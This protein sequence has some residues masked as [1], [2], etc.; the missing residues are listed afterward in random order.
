MTMDIPHASGTIREALQSAFENLA[1]SSNLGVEGGEDSY[2]LG[3]DPEDTTKESSQ[4]FPWPVPSGKRIRKL[5]E[6]LRIQH[7]CRICENEEDPSN[8]VICRGCGPARRSKWPAHRS[9]L[10]K[11]EDHQPNLPLN[12]A[13]GPEAPSCE[14]IDYKTVVYTTSLLDSSR[15]KRQEATEDHLEDLWSTWFGVPRNQK[16]PHYPQLHIYPRLETMLSQRG[17]KHERQ[18]PRLISFVG[19]TGSGK[20]TL[21]RAMI[22][23]ARPS[24]LNGFRVPVPGIVD[25]EFDSTSSDVHIFADPMTNSTQDPIFFVDSEGF[26]GSE[27]PISRRIH[28]DAS[29]DILNRLRL[30]GVH[31]GQ[32]AFERYR[33]HSETAMDKIDL[34]WGKIEFPNIRSDD[35]GHVAAETHRLVVKH[36]YPRLL[37]AFSDVICFVTNNSRAVHGILNTLFTWAKDGLEKTLN[38]GVRPGLIIILNKMPEQSGLSDG[39]TATRRL[40]QSFQ[41]TSWFQ[42][43]RKKWRDRGRKIETAEQLVLCYYSFFQVVSIP[44]FNKEPTTANEISI[45]IKELYTK[46][47]YIS[48]AIQNKRQCFNLE[49]DVPNLN[50][51]LARSATIL[52]RDY[53]DTLDL[54]H[55]VER[56]DGLPASFGEHLTGVLSSMA[57]HRDLHITSRVGG[58]A[59]LLG[60]V[61]PYLAACIF[62]QYRSLDGQGALEREQELADETQRGLRR[63]RNSYWRCETKDKLGRR[64]MNYL[65]THEK[66]HQFTRDVPSRRSR[67]SSASNDWVEHETLE[68][69]R[70]HDSY[71]VDNF[72]ERLWSHVSRLKAEESDIHGC[73]ASAARHC[74]VSKISSQR[75]CLSCLSRCPTN[76]LPCNPLQH[77]IC[78]SCI[79]R[80]GH[81]QPGDS[82][83]YFKTCPLGCRFTVWPSPWM[84]RVKPQCAGA[85]IL[86]LDGGGIRGIVE[87]VILSEIQK[88]VGLGIPIQDLFD[89]ALG[90]STGGIIALAVFE[91]HWTLDHAKRLFR[92]LATNAFTLRPRLSVPVISAMIEPFLDHRYTSAGI[93]GALRDTLGDDFLF[94]QP[95]TSPQSSGRA[96]PIGDATKVGVVTCLEGRSQACLIANYSR[97]P[98][99]SEGGKKTYDYLLRQDEQIT[100]F[101]TW[102][103][104]RATSAAPM[105]FRPYRHRATEQ[106]Y[107]DGGVVRNNPV[108]LA[109]SEAERIWR[110][111]RPPDIIVSIGTGVQV[112]TNG[113]MVTG[114]TGHTSDIK[115]LLPLGLRNK[116]KLGLDM[117]NATLDCHR[118]WV[119][120][121]STLNSTLNRNSHRIDVGLKDKPPDLDDF[122][123]VR[124]L[125]NDSETY[126]APSARG[127]RYFDRQY[128][129]P[130]E[131]IMAVA[132]RLVACL[133]FCYCRISNYLEPGRYEVPLHCRLDPKSPG[134]KAL[135]SLDPEF[136]LREINPD[137]PNVV[138]RIRHLN[139]RGFDR[140]TLIS[141]VQIIISPGYYEKVIEVRFTTRGP[142]WRQWEPIGGF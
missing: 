132:R 91:K 106:P 29:R 90:T 72:F 121:K 125:E 6:D 134:A 41:A 85:R 47:R 60:D 79:E 124:D 9:C 50:A 46:I 65:E 26:S 108:V 104:A 61:I 55:V 12:K 4:R 96:I 110:S 38:Q 99:R 84:I 98:Q 141:R 83:A 64:C 135:L 33:E 77:G 95:K 136:R 100:D 74:G 8:F 2:C 137:G 105:L 142:D 37:Y 21:I 68:F 63:F 36:V 117:I 81:I 28:S 53:K 58:E 62:A 15:V 44:T 32:T 102:Q 131:H 31:H 23:M 70:Y 24:S 78:E 40:L 120:F 34:Q 57:K 25:D 111:S 16:G 115:N 129:R 59:E 42:E 128:S 73:L 101:K 82:I 86:S 113:E 130:H 3:S 75:T 30:G 112:D 114:D 22:R 140:Q 80:C 93:E 54:R 67:R 92:S 138:K 5:A 127:I 123:R 35:Y 10:A 19:D 118:E 103:A 71:D 126:L 119:H 107:I 20:S 39:N 116:L 48:G 52:G 69:G 11:C 76:M 122:M 45:R 7:L 51:Y 94:G 1:I 18:Y 139:P 87:L 43:F 89:L 17:G 27:N 13:D 49:L 133:F 109:Y 97:D 66:G 14:E 56:Q 88:T